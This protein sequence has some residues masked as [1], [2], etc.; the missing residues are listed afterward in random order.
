MASLAKLFLKVHINR[1]KTKCGI[2]TND[3]LH[4][5]EFLLKG[6][7]VNILVSTALIPKEF[8]GMHPYENFG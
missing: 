1:I 6:T 3:Y 7:Y 8:V 5:Q 4:R 2:K